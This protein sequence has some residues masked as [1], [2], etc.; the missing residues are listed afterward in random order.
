LLHRA[1]T[2]FARFSDICQPTHARAGHERL[3]KFE[4]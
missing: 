4:G 2:E 1:C 3:W